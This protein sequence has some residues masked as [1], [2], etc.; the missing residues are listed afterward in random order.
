MM[1]HIENVG[2][3]EIDEA[4]E[5]S[6]GFL[7]KDGTDEKLRRLSS[8][9]RIPPG[10][11][12][13]TVEGGG[14]LLQDTGQP[15]DQQTNMDQANVLN[16]RETFVFIDEPVFELSA[17]LEI[18]EPGHK[19]SFY[20]KIPLPSLK[21]LSE[22]SFLS[23]MLKVA[24]SLSLSPNFDECASELWPVINSP[25]LL[26]LLSVPALRPYAPV[27]SYSYIIS[28]QIPSKEIYSS[29][30][31]LL[32]PHTPPPPELDRC[33]VCRKI[34]SPDDI[35]KVPPCYH[36]AHKTCLDQCIITSKTCITCGS[37]INGESET[38]VMQ[39]DLS[40]NGDI[41]AN[42][43]N[44]SGSI[45]TYSPVRGF[46]V[47]SLKIITLKV[48]YKKS[49]DNIVVRSSGLSTFN[50]SD[51]EVTFMRDIIQ[52]E[53]SDQTVAL[54]I[55]F[56]S[57]HEKLLLY[58]ISETNKNTFE[59]TLNETLDNE[60]KHKKKI[61]DFLKEAYKKNIKFKDIEIHPNLTHFL[62]EFYKIRRC[63]LLNIIRTM[64][65]KQQNAAKRPVPAF[66]VFFSSA[67]SVYQ[68]LYCKIFKNILK[69]Q[70]HQPQQQSRPEPHQLLLEEQLLLEKLAIKLKL[71]RRV[72]KKCTVNS[73]EQCLQK[74]F[75]KRPT[76][77]DSLE[78]ETNSSES[79]IRELYEEITLEIAKNFDGNHPYTKDIYM[80][81]PSNIQIK[82]GKIYKSIRRQLQQP[83]QQPPPQPPQQ[84]PPQP[85]Q[86]PPPQPPQ[87]QHIIIFHR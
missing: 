74:I 5:N 79:R 67:L 25:P 21:P 61:D 19:Q 38:M 80:F 40:I 78:A 52:I 23:A 12:S 14:I 43:E 69:C 57:L 68:L 33:R 84:P 17:L 29:L 36:H 22:T 35:I 49:N 2:K 27:P 50:R 1:E 24:S 58:H 8:Q 28:D 16:C 13:N 82:L 77:L 4:I 86:Q 70:K 44:G 9:E 3:H 30:R 32:L 55:C 31:K 48:Q 81:L 47:D 45:I 10:P 46:V 71:L 15:T 63:E 66:D 20:G 7:K 56:L 6:T 72:M 85:P 65:F 83:P 73:L 76:L 34:F 62:K 60:F 26:Q 18:F 59:S 54:D 64:E 11:E 53:K 51:V 37:T 41:R 87:Q 75:L 42:F 39:S